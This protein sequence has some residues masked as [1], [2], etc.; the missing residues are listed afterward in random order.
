[1]T[2]CILVACATTPSPD[3]QRR[4]SDCLADCRT[5]Q[6]PPP[7]TGPF[8]QNAGKPDQSDVCEQRCESI[9]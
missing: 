7:R 1:M 5:A 6:M 2:A 9:K 4:I 8:D 3:R